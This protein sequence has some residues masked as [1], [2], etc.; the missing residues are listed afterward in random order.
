MELFVPAFIFF[1]P[2][3][4]LLKPLF[5]QLCHQVE[6]GDNRWALGMIQQHN[7]FTSV[8]QGHYW[9]YWNKKICPFS[10]IFWDQEK[11]LYF[12]FRSTCRV[13][14][15][16]GSFPTHSEIQETHR[17]AVSSTTTSILVSNADDNL[18][19]SWGPVGYEGARCGRLNSRNS[20]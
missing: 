3:T 9:R 12:P 15:K 5:V 19:V 13:C 11:Y 16:F 10:Q 18:N 8:K 7:C 6:Y 14:K 1:Q 17:I 4:S 20:D 2:L